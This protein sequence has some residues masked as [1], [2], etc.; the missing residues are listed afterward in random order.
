MKK[1]IIIQEWAHEDIPRGDIAFIADEDLLRLAEEIKPLVTASRLFDGAIRFKA[2]GNVGVIEA[3]GIR[4]EVRP[5]LAVREFLALIRYALGGKVPPNHFR[6]MTELS[7]GSGFED[8]LCMLFCDEVDEIRRIGLSRKYKEITKPLE[9]L[10]GRPMWNQNFPW[11]GAEQGEIIC[12]YNRITYDSLDNQLL[13]AGLEKAVIWTKDVKVR[14]RAIR[15]LRLLHHLTT[16]KRPDLSDFDKVTSGYNRLNEHYEAPHALSRMFLFGLRPSSFFD[17]GADHIF[18]LSLNMA[19][20][21]ENFVERLLKAILEQH[22]FVLRSQLPDRGA[23]LD[24]DEKVYSSVRPDLLVWR[25][26]HIRAV[27]DAKY[28]DYWQLDAV[29]SRPV[30]KVINEDLYQLFFYQQRLQR[31]YGLSNPPPAFIVCPLPEDD[32]REDIQILSKRFRRIIWQAGNERSGDV[33][34]VFIPMTKFL[35][36]VMDGNSEEKA[37]GHVIGFED[38]HKMFVQVA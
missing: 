9:V 13:L 36:S 19:N 15:H 34:L 22:G 23:L 5:R 6:S 16:R 24:G 14:H 18:G 12:R 11:R 33:K 1:R 8:A 3:K 27:I 17:S 30:R 25:G 31:K 2:G 38:L 20:L 29:T 37:I 32:E 26:D 35:R 4:I 21:F 28:K 10:R 7:W